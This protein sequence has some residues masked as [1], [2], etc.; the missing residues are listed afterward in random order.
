MDAAPTEKQSMPISSRPNYDLDDDD[1][2]LAR[3]PKLRSLLVIAR[4]ILLPVYLASD[5]AG[6]RQQQRHSWLVLLGAIFGTLAVLCAIFELSDVIPISRSVLSIVELIAASIAIVVVVLGIYSALHPDWLLQR[7]LAE[8][9]RFVKF[10]L[11]LNPAVWYGRTGEE[12]RSTVEAMSQSLRNPDEHV[13]HEWVTWRIQIAKRFEPLTKDIPA[14][15]VEEIVDY[16]K[17]KR[18]QNQQQYFDRQAKRRHRWERWTRNVSPA[19]F[20]LS[21]VAAFSHFL[22]EWLAGEEHH[23]WLHFLAGVFVLLAAALPVLAM[24][25]RT[26]RAAH[27]FGRNKLRFEGMSYFLSEILVLAEAQETPS[28]VMPLLREAEIALDSEHRA[29][30]RLM[31]EAEWFG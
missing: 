22:F 15:V 27:E 1:A 26:F 20:F 18:L 30:L 29:W 24:G 14:D 21:I 3:W 25:V 28:S 23:G 11:L 10:H 13:I 6:M 31:V 2:D 16:Y 19:C 8:Q 17:A 9:C 5:A 4:E 7:F 12:M